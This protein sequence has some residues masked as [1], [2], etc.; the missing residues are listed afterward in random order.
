MA[1]QTKPVVININ[2]DKTWS[3]TFNS[4][5]A[6]VFI[7]KNDLP[8]SVVNFGFSAPYFIVLTDTQFTDSQASSYATE[9]GLGK[10]AA[11]YDSSVVFISPL[12]DG[13]WAKAPTGRAS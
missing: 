13:G 10:I 2:E 4:F 3:H 8:G 11:A 7:P 9:S 6:K 12:C 1:I 5:S